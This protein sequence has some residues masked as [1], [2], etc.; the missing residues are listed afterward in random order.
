MNVH[1][2]SYNLIPKRYDVAPCSP[3]GNS[4][5]LQTNSL[6]V[7]SVSFTGVSGR[8]A[9]ALKMLAEYGITDIY[10]GKLLLGSK[11]M[12]R[13]LKNGVF[14]QKLPKLVHSLEY[15]EDSLN[16]VQAKF[17]KYVKKFAKT[18]PN[19]NLRDVIASLKKLHSYKLLSHSQQPIFE[20]MTRLASRM[21]EHLFEQYC[22]LIKTTDN[23][24]NHEPVILPFSERE[25]KYKLSRIAEAIRHRNNKKEVHDIIILEKMAKKLL[26]SDTYYGYVM[27][28]RKM[29]KEQK[30][31]EQMKPDNFRRNYANFY[32]LKTFLDLSSLKRNKDLQKLF[33]ATGAKI[34]GLPDI[35]PFTRKGFI[36]DLKKITKK[37][38]DKDLYKSIMSL[39]AKLPTSKTD[40]SAFVVKCANASPEKI[41]YA[42]FEGS[43]ASIDHIK[44]KNKK[45][46]NKLSNYA[47]SCVQVNTEKTNIPL[48][49]W[50]RMHPEVYTH[51][52]T[53]IDRLI[54]LYHQGIFKKVGLDVSYITDLSDTLYVL[55]PEE[56]RFVADL[57]KLYS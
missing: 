37:L 15:Y 44:P 24:L 16:P 20:E 32:A 2:V 22:S 28:R 50:M 52:Q 45:G 40:V 43:I 46:S 29:T 27:K 4:Y 38:N 8:E 9:K 21:P 41:G 34:H 1:G 30:L 14:R 48:D 31:V 51:A 3:L 36:Y 47:L 6:C 23:I 26:N 5:R 12:E 25:F 18:N 49:E 10:T 54:E 39:A 13:L 42:L 19:A 56:K 53:H 55:S 17:Y 7:D 33:D 57:S 11:S 35:I